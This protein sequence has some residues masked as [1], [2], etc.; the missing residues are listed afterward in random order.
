MSET[1]GETVQWYQESAEPTEERWGLT[2]Q[3]QMLLFG[4][5]GQINKY[6]ILASEVLTTKKQLAI[7]YVAS[8]WPKDEIP[9]AWIEK[10][11]AALDERNSLIK[12]YP[13]FAAKLLPVP[14]AVEIAL[15][16]DFMPKQRGEER[17]PEYEGAWSQAVAYCGNTG[18]ADGDR[19]LEPYARLGY[20]LEIQKEWYAKG[21]RGDMRSGSG[22]W[23]EF[24]DPH[25][26][27]GIGKY[28]LRAVDEGVLF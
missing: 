14:S 24:P 23:V 5:Q 6:S 11:K 26:A 27:A 13:D 18:R 28:P 2:A 10:H 25:W 20:V 1:S 19:A 12:R 3:E 21:W 7:K 15:D 4:D 9:A 17:D 8:F 16:K 22:A